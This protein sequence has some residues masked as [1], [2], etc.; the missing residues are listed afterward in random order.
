MGAFASTVV[1]SLILLILIV[2]E[3]QVIELS[4]DTAELLQT[5]QQNIPRNS[6]SAKISI[7]Q[8]KNSWIEI[9]LTLDGQ[10][11]PLNKLPLT[12][13]IVAYYLK[14]G[15]TVIEWKQYG[16]TRGWQLVSVTLNG[17]PEILNPV[18]IGSETGV[19][20]PGETATIRISMPSSYD[21][22]SPVQVILVT[23]LGSRAVAVA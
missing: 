17:A 23:Y 18:N 11:I 4:A 15:D 3:T 13:I 21:Q 12:D 9:Q 5:Y 19:I 22:S 2:A 16:D 7:T 1:G 10:G 20:D 8:K 6:Q 14:N